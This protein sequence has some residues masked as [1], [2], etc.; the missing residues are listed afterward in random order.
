MNFVTA[1]L[2]LLLILL[3]VLSE[4]FIKK[5]IKNNSTRYL[6]MGV[7]L[8]VLVGM[9]FYFYLKS[10]ESFA[11]LNTIWQGMNV[12]AIALLSYFYFKERFSKGQF[13]G[14]SLILFGILLVNY[15][16]KLEQP[17]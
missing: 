13:I 1:G 4:F 15:T 5:S 12:V 6:Y 2:L 11:I 7:G 10:G 3:E 16:E 9:V 8:Y 17:I 14:I